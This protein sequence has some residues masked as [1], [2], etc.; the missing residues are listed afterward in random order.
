MTK[1]YDQAYYDRW[2]RD[3]QHRQWALPDIRRK[4]TMVLGLAEYL[5]ERPVR[6]VL[7]VGCGT[8]LC[9][10]GLQR[11]VGPAGRIVGIDESLD[12][13]R[14]ARGRAADRGWGNVSVLHSRVSRA[15]IPGRADAAF[16]CATHDILQSTQ[17]LQRVLEHLRP[18]ARVVAGGGKFAAPW[19]IAMNFQVMA[20]HRPFVRS[21]DG[22][23]RP[24][25]LLASLVT[26]L[27]VT[28]FAL[29]TGYCAVGTVRQD[30]PRSRSRRPSST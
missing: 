15:D 6:S 10:D 24:W 3:P 12:M 8:G 23:A 18:G 21:F 2:Y 19:M 13:V 29:G 7:D 28:E 27:K 22:F 20:L 9:F 5:L 26:N 16:F 11:V 14:L 1:Q 30:L 4:V 25:A 17:D